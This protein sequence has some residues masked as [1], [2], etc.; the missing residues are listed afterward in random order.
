MHADVGKPELAELVELLELAE[1]AAAESSAELVEVDV[2]VDVS[3][4]LE[5]VLGG[6]VVML[7]LNPG[8][9]PSLPLQAATSTRAARTARRT[10][11]A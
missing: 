8:P 10:G 5:V 3:P 2:E 11:P 6:A 4:P 1:L 9:C 7:E